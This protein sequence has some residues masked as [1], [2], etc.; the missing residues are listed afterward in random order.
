MCKRVDFN[1]GE[2]LATPGALGALKRNLVDP[3]DYLQ[4]HLSCDWGV[5]CKEDQQAND[6]ALKTGARILSAYFLPDEIKLWIITD[7]AIDENGTR[8]ATTLLLPEE[9]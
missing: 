1:C 3:W 5:V 7:A 9:Y 8:A 6:Q 2:V 4:R